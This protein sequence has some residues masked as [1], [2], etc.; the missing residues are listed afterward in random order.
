VSPNVAP[1]PFVPPGAT[2]TA[3]GRQA[4]SLVARELRARGVRLLLGPDHH[5]PTM[6]LPFQL[7]GIAVRTVPTGADTLMLGRALREALAGRPDAAVLHCETFGT[8]A[9]AGLRAALADA[10]AAGT[11][12]VVDETHSLLGRDHV[13]GDHHVA[14]LRKLL[15]V[16]DGAWVTGLRTPPDLHRTARD[17]HIT[18]LRRDALRLGPGWRER[19]DEVEDLI[20]DDAWAPAAISPESLAVL[21]ALD[22]DGYVSRRRRSAARLRNGLAGLTVVNPTG[23]AC[24]VV[25]SHPEAERIRVGLA[26]A[27]V[28]GPVHWERPADL[29]RGRAWRT[30]L[31]SL[32]VDGPYD[33]RDMDRIAER[34]RTLASPALLSPPEG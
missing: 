13:P 17:K 18:A 32:P 20:D 28:V 26:A 25:V 8:P 6:F 30:D 10:R 7:E 33:E 16:P 29:P 34:V 9:D 31:V 15:P 12:V 4:L 27:D 3:F 24:C 19:L 1:P 21:R 5:C 2:L 11:V 22:A 14:S 23:S